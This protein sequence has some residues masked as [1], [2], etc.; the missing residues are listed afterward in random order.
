MFVSAAALVLVRTVI[1][2]DHLLLQHDERN[3]FRFN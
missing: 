3:F 2:G 1:T